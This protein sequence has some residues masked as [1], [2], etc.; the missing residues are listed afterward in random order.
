MLVWRVRHCSRNTEVQ[1]LSHCYC[2]RAPPLSLIAPAMK[3]FIK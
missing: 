2:D 1:E 3:E